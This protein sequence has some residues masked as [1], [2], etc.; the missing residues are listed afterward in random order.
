[1]VFYVYTRRMQRL[2]FIFDFDGTVANSLAHLIKISNRLSKEIGFKHI[3]A[4]DIHLLK[5][6]NSYEII[7]YL[8]IPIIKI[9]C[10]A[11]RVKREMFDDITSI[12]PASGLK[13]TL[14][15]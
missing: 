7:Q 14:L 4:E 1:M 11:A 12:E 9:P 15:K 10:L 2:I 13:E 3:G 8:K 5:N 6:K